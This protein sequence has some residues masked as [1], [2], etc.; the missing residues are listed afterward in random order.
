[1]KQHAESLVAQL[2]DPSRWPG[3]GAIDHLQQ[4]QG[5]AGESKGRGTTD[6][7]LA[8]M[9]IIHQL[10]EEMIKILIDDADFYTQLRLYPLPLKPTRTKDKKK[11]TF[12]DYLSDLNSTVWFQNKKYIMEKAKRL[13]TIRNSMVHKLTEPG[14]LSVVEK[15]VTE[16]WELYNSLSF[17]ALEA[18]M[19]FQSDFN[20]LSQNPDWPP[21]DAVILRDDGS[22]LD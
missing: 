20:D 5:L 6:G 2:K 9:L 12:G 11:G 18:R 21:K 14:A 13:N 15:N 19:V 1:M 4:L 22:H 7:Y 3:F 17:L 8:A 10:T 16:A